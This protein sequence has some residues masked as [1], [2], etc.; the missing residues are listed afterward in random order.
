[1]SENNQTQNYRKYAEVEFNS[2]GE[3]YLAVD[4]R[5]VEFRK[6]YPEG[7][8]IISEP[9]IPA[10]ARNAEEYQCEARIFANKEDAEPIANGYARRT[11]DGNFDGFSWAQTAAIGA[12]LEN[13]GFPARIINREEV[14]SLKEQH[15]AATEKKARENGEREQAEIA[16]QLEEQNAEPGPAEAAAESEQAVPLQEADEGLVK[17]ASEKLDKEITEKVSETAPAATESVEAEPAEAAEEQNQPP[18]EETVKETPVEEQPVVSGEQSEDKET[19]PVEQAAVSDTTEEPKEKEPEP[20]SASSKDNAKRKSHDDKKVF[21]NKIKEAA[22]VLSNAEAALK[23]G[24]VD[25]AVG[26]YKNAAQLVANITGSLAPGQKRHRKT[27][28]EKTL[29]ERVETLKKA[30]EE[31]KVKGL[32]SWEKLDC[33]NIYETDESEEESVSEV[34]SEDESAVA[35]N[36]AEP[37]NIEFEDEALELIAKHTFE[38]NENGENIG[39]RRLHTILE[40]ILSDIAFNAGGGDAP[41]ITVSINAEYIQKQLG[42]AAKEADLNKFIL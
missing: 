10:D 16:A 39:A 34:P 30:L 42:S 31:K 35:E 15:K 32:V 8:I 24:K 20:E 9:K 40:Q 12:A 14:D 6:K 26:G 13:A 27:Q 23:K 25:E 7:R 4:S 37:G 38:A 33:I 2:A 21:I 19:E 3:P 18:V 29:I 22:E 11:T 1:M 17:K 5:K 28:E 41:E 36:D